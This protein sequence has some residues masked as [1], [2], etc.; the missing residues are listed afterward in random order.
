VKVTVS[1]TVDVRDSDDVKVF[2]AQAMQG[3]EQAAAK[4]PRTMQLLSKLARAIDHESG[5][6]RADRSKEGA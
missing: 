3:D 5:A 4:R 2:Y 1:I 6:V